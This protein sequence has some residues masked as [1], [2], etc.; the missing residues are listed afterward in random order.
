MNYEPNTADWQVGDI[1]IHDA[2]AKKP[3]ML[4]V[5]VDHLETDE[6]R[7]Y[8]TVYLDTERN[9]Q[10]RYWNPMRNLHDPARFNITPPTSAEIV[11]R[12]IAALHGGTI[13]NDRAMLI[14]HFWAKVKNGGADHD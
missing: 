14:R 8:A 6:G 11:E 12:F 2:D 13:S 4:M 3:H 7:E 5:V 1:V 9:R 10:K